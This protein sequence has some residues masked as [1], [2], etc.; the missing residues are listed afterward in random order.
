MQAIGT[1]AGGIAHDFNN[2]LGAII[3]Y[4]SLLKNMMKENH[5][6]YGHV[7]TIE[8]SAER[9]ADLTR[10][11]L[12]FARGGKYRAEPVSLNDVV[13]RVLPIIQ[14]TFDRAIVIETRLAESLPTTEGDLGQLEHSLLNL[15]LNARDAM[16]EG[17]SLVIET[18][19]ARIG[20]GF[21]ALHPWARTGE[22]VRLTVSDTGVGMTPETRMR[23]F[24]PFFT[25]KKPGSGTGAGMG[26]AMVY[27]AVKNHGGF[28]EVHS[29]PGRG[30]TMNL[31]LPVSWRIRQGDSPAPEKPVRGVK[32]TVLVV[33][34]E[35]ALRDLAEAVLFSAGYRVLAARNGEEAC[36][37][38]RDLG[39][40]VG[41]VLL[42]IEMPGMG[43]KQAFLTMR[44]MRP[45]L[46]VLVATGHGIEGAAS[47]ILQMGG[48]GFLGK[49]FRAKELLQ[50]VRRVLDSK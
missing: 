40:K 1:L 38:L 41:L 33:D 26:L 12:G 34:D 30:T 13:T 2:T 21:V 20:E 23:L 7:A 9:A 43:G 17:G 3:G 32:E 35:P 8:R 6:F 45:G 29:E 28:I 22:F 46:P 14:R 44:G 4:T 11:L 37:I 18:A 36:E 47:E 25:T 24:E 48:N 42:D 27:G 5:P 19:P 49:P 50:A 15:C 39:K 16:P 10:K 31:Y